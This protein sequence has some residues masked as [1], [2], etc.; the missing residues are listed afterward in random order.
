MNVEPLLCNKLPLIVNI[1]PVTVNVPL[2]VNVLLFN[3]QPTFTSPEATVK[4]AFALIVKFLD[5]H[6]AVE[7]VTLC[8]GFIKT[9]SQDVGGTTPPTQVAGVFQSPD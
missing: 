5:T 8:V 2:F 3:V 1:P 9:F 7:T 6:A 4:V